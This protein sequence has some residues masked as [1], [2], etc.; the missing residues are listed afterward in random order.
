MCLWVYCTK[1]VIF[2]VKGTIALERETGRCWIFCNKRF[3][4]DRQ[5]NHKQIGSL[6][7]TSFLLLFLINIWYVATFKC[8]KHR[9]WWMNRQV[10]EQCCLAVAL[11]K[12]GHVYVVHYQGDDRVLVSSFYI[13]C[14]GLAH[15]PCS[16]KGG[17]LFC[18]RVI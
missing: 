7:K 11:D 14:W 17:V 1:N 12:H 5:C 4:L 9:P 6:A 10:C 18:S 2:S 15:C 16:N 13:V 8:F 3:T